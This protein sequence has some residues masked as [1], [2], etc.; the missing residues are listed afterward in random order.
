MTALVKRV[1]ESMAVTAAVAEDME[2]SMARE[3]SP[4]ELM[5]C[6]CGHP[7]Y[8]HVKPWYFGHCKDC[9]KRSCEAFRERS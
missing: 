1:M 3:Y 4:Y 8:S 6:I 9:G 5:K 2:N 7:R